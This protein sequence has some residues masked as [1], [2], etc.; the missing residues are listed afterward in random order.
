MKK[1]EESDNDIASDSIASMG[2]MYMLVGTYTSNEGSKGIYVYK[3]DTD[4]GKSDS[5]SMVEVANPSFLAVSPD[6]KYVYSVG[7]GGENDSFAHSF[8]FNKE[9]GNLTLLNSQHTEGSSPAYITLD[10]KGHNVITANYGGG[11]I[12]QFNVNSDGTLSALTNLFQFEGKGTDSIRQKQPHLHSV[13]YSPDGLYMFATDLGTDKIYRYKSIYSVFEGQPA[14]LENDT[15]VFMTPEGTGP[16]HFDFH[17]NG[18]YF[19]L[20]GEISGEI[21]VYDY[22][23]GNLQQKQKIVA[24][25]VGAKGSA[26]IHVSP[27]GRFLYASNRLQADGIVIFAIDSL[28]GTLT[29]IGYQLTARHPRNFAIT[30]NGQFLLVASRDDNVIQVFSIDKKSGLLTNTQKDISIDKPVFITFARLD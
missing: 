2:E 25:S 5:V 16:R 20:L 6:E 22:N 28:E 26:D 19:Y 21:I 17:P 23:K 15:V 12:S 29:K 4:T 9:I 1:T 7:E 3:F 8:A 27:N 11:S 10:A 13:R 18:L 30:P 24:D 14:F